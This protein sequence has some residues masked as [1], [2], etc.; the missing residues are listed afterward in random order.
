MCSVMK[1]CA[2]FSFVAV[3]FLMHF[4]NLGI[5]VCDVLCVGTKH[6]LEHGLLSY[7]K[8]LSFL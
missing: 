4:L 2:M 5:A 3:I 8:S 1:N 6:M 7:D